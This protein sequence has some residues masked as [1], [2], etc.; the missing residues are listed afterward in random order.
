MWKT[1]F[2]WI[3]VLVAVPV[4]L[5]LLVE[6]PLAAMA[7]PFC[8][9]LEKLQDGVYVETSMSTETRAK[10]LKTLAESEA[11]VTQF[12]G[13]MRYIPR[14]IVCATDACYQHIGGGG[15]RVGSLGAS[16]LLVAPQGIDAV[17]MSHE[18]SHVELYGRVGF[19]NM[20]LD[21]VPVWFNEGVAVLVSDDPAYLAPPHNGGDRCRVGPGEHMPVYPSEWRDRLQQDGQM[22]YAE[23]ACQVDYW[24]IANG[25]P[26]A[27]PALLDK[28]HAGQS[29]DSLYH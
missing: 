24:V 15:A 27:V 6:R 21:V 29:F 7:C 3:I 10:L 4:C 16:L 20:F 12:Y 23:A 11:R 19:W 26:A 18:L 9:G 17:L 1:I 8:F 2:I 13:Q 14:V 5:T 25:G 22:L 28:L